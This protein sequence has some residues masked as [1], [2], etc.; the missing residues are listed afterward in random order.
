M[1]YNVRLEIETVGCDFADV[2]VEAGNREEAIDLA[3]AKYR[4]GEEA[5]DSY[6]SDEIE[7]RLMY[8]NHK[9]WLVD[10]HLGD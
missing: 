10:E 4:S 7:N 2:L 9:D 1:K 5:L 8:E 6:Q 3:V